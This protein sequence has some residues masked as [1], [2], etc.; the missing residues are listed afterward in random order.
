MSRRKSALCKIGPLC[1]SK[2]TLRIK[3][4]SKIA[5]LDNFI[6]GMSATVER[7]AALNI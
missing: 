5:A 4:A 6:P 7:A 1:C 3:V 2:V